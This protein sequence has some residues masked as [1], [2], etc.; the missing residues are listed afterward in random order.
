[1]RGKLAIAAA[2][3]A[4]SWFGAPSVTSAALLIN[5][6]DSDSVNTP[7][8]DAFE[9]VEIYE[10]T[11]TSVPLD[12][13]VLVFYNGNGNVPYR[14]QDLDGFSTNSSG[15]FVA[16]SVAG[17]QLVIPGNTIQNGVDAIALYTGNGTDFVTGTGGTAPSKT[18]LIDAVVYK[19]GAD[20]D[21]VG[22]DTALLDAGSMLDEFAR[23]GSAAQGALDSL[24]RFPN[25]SGAARDTT[26][27]TFMSPTPGAANE[28]PEPASLCFLAVGGLALIA[29]R[30]RAR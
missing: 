12:G 6:M 1:M 20:I 26:S 28:V 27:W 29:R 13:L 30:R 11:G 5:E 23:D 24:G 22:L 4:A 25:G 7:T 21:G 17:A 16:G 9:F 14:V 19:T 18:N 2:L 15:Y 10:T 3:A 8:T